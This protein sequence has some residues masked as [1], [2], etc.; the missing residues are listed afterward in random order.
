VHDTLRHALA[1]ELRELLDEVVVVQDDRAV[2]AD[3]LRVRVRGD[4]GTV[5]V[6]AT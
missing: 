2:G 4:G 3:G 6:P 1:V 5:V